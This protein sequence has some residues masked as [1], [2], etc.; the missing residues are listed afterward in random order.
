MIFFGSSE[1]YRLS[2]VFINHSRNFAAFQVKK[3]LSLVFRGAMSSFSV[4]SELRL[5]VDII[6]VVPERLL[7]LWSIGTDHKGV[8]RVGKPAENPADRLGQCLVLKS[9]YSVIIQIL[10]PQCVWANTVLR[11]NNYDD[12]M[13]SCVSFFLGLTALFTCNG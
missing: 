11:R 9:I 2:T 4:F 1:H 6:Q 3:K 5:L 13:C 8:I 12:A 7:V 10:N